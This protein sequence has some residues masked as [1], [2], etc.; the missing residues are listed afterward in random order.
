VSISTSSGL[1]PVMLSAAT[2]SAHGATVH[3]LDQRVAEAGPV[4][5]VRAHLLA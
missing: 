5:G 1:V 2:A 3:T 4:L